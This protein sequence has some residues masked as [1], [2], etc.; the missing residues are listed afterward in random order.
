MEPRAALCECAMTA[1]SSEN[2][3]AW[4]SPSISMGASLPSAELLTLL[5]AVAPHPPYGTFTIESTLRK[6]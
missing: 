1:F 4:R 3:I 2:I 6:P 5:R